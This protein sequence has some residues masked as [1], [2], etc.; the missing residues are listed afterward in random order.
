MTMVTKAIEQRIGWGNKLIKFPAGLRVIRAS[1]LP[2]DAEIK[3]WLDEL[4]AGTNSEVT[5][6][7]RNYGIGLSNEEVEEAR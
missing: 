3:W 7:F 1:N 4:P 6:W 2:A 5:S